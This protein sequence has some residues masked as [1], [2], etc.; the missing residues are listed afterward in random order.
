MNI[1]KETFS[2]SFSFLFNEYTIYIVL[3]SIFIIAVY[4]IYENFFTSGEKLVQE[5]KKFTHFKTNHYSECENKFESVDKSK[6]SHFLIYGST[7]SGKTNFLKYYL[8]RHN[9]DYIIFGRHGEEWPDNQFINYEQL[10]QIDFNKI[11]NKTIILDDLG[12]FKN[13]KTIVED[14]FRNGRHN[15]VQIIYLAHYALRMFYPL[16]EKI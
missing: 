10:N 9:L 12:A 6:N 13:L 2:E 16:L 15:N 14:L 1:P 7:A 11:N 8:T 5:F 4:F 3:I